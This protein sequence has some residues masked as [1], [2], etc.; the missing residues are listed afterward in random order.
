MIWDE[1]DFESDQYQVEYADWSA[2]DKNQAELSKHQPKCSLL[3]CLCGIG[4]TWSFGNGKAKSE[5]R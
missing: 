5:G 4:T 3:K 1:D 2:E